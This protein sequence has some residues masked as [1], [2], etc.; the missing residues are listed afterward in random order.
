[1]LLESVVF[2]ISADIGLTATT[3]LTASLEGLLICTCMSAGETLDGEELLIGGDLGVEP[4]VTQYCF[5]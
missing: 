3:I 4:A 5:P 1:M 2:G